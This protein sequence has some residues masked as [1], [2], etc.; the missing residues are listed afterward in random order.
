MQDRKNAAEALMIRRSQ[1]HRLRVAKSIKNGMS[2]HEPRVLLR[3]S[4]FVRPLNMV[5]EKRTGKNS[6]LV[7]TSASV[8]KNRKPSATLSTVPTVKTALADAALVPGACCC[9]PA[10]P[11]AVELPALLPL[12]DEE[13]PD[14]LA[15]PAEGAEVPVA[16]AS[17]VANTPV[18]LAFCAEADAVFML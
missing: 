3:A 4:R 1:P 8:Y 13:E 6:H 11:P 16:V 9:G 17:E 15:A 7:A 2:G 5:E 12:P 10:L 18:P 14:G